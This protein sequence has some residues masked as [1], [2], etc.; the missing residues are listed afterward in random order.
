MK[1][2]FFFLDPPYLFSNNSSYIPQ[3]NE[4]DMTSMIVD[5]LE[6]IQT[7]KCKVML[8]INELDL[9]S[10][11]FRNYIKGKYDRTYQI[12]KKKAVHLIIC[13]Y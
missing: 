2:R 13:N 7:C 4:A 5:I 9:L 8:I 12:S 6:F 3:V 1:M 10:H 11:L